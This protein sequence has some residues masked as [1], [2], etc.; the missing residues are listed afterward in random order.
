MGFSYQFGANPQIDW[1]RILVADT[2]ECKHIFEDE[3]ILSVYAIAGSPWQSGMM[4]SD[5][6]G[7]A[8]PSTP[9]SP[10]RIAAILLKALAGNR[11]R[12]SAVTKLLDVNVNPG[13]AAKA[14]MQQ[15]NDWLETDYNSGAFVMIE[16]CHTSWNFADRFWK[17]V[18]RQLGV[19][20]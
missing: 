5:T 6:Q 13:A 17:Q 20:T 9:A 2:Q 8:L 14:L 12:L 4:F 1:P 7:K 3:E 18:Q 19:M 16:Q 15:A 10:Y 11:A